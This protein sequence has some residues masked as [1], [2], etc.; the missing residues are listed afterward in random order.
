MS[1]QGRVVL[2]F[3]LDRKSQR[4]HGLGLAVCVSRRADLSRSAMSLP[5][6]SCNRTR[7]LHAACGHASQ[8]EA[9]ERRGALIFE[10][11]GARLPAQP[12]AIA[13]SRAWRS[14]Q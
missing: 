5:G 2:P 6:V 13:A 12:P 11:F 4:R 9:I 14:T 7:V 10:P 8:M 1:E 3:A